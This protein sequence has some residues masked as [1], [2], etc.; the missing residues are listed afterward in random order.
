MRS[1]SGISAVAA[2]LL[3]V[4]GVQKVADP[5]GTAG[6]LRA[7]GLP[8]RRGFVR[9]GALFE[10]GVGA[11]ALVLAG[12]VAPALMAASYAAFAGFVAVALRRSTPISSC[13]CFG[14]VDTPPSGLHVVL[15]VVFTL[16]AAAQAVDGVPPVDRFAGSVGTAVAAVALVAA[17][18][19]LVVVAMTALPIARAAG[20]QATRSGAA[21]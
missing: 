18:V 10:A 8:S 7:A 21:R 4:A 6:A 5:A 20:R 13:G 16:A 11:G 15:N 3:V 14:R 1:A 12:P 2:V 9:A 17:T 19:T